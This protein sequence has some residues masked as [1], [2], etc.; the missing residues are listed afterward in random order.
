MQR[1]MHEDKGTGKQE[2]HHMNSHWLKDSPDHRTRQVLYFEYI[3]R[4]NIQF[5]D[6]GKELQIL[7]RDENVIVLYSNTLTLLR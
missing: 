5:L 2:Q 6:I 7:G 4:K 1:C 3:A